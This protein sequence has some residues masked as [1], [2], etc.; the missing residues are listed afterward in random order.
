MKREFREAVTSRRV[1]LLEAYLARYSK[2]ARTARAA[3]IDTVR[4]ILDQR[5]KELAQ[6]QAYE[7][8]HPPFLSLSPRQ[9][10]I[11]I[12][13]RRAEPDSTLR[14]LIDSVWSEVSGVNG[15]RYPASVSL[16]LSPT[17]SWL[18]LNAYID[19]RRDVQWKNDSSLMVTIPGALAGL[20][21]L[22]RIQSRIDA[23]LTTNVRTVTLVTRLWK[24]TSEYMTF[25]ASA[26][27]G[28]SL[29]VLDMMDIT[30]HNQQDIRVRGFSD[31]TIALPDST[32]KPFLAMREFLHVP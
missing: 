24:N 32:D 9:P 26:P 25:Y 30:T 5:K 12:T 3:R 8:A 11:S 21:I 13:S 4:I 15:L 14:L 22:H 7:N 16:D 18:M 17:A 31:S 20:T 19:V 27:N 28:D 6:E 23:S 29:R 10:T 1:D 2:P